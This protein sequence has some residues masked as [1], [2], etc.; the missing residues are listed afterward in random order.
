ME[1]LN[2]FKPKYK[3]DDIIYYSAILY[4]EKGDELP[5]QTYVGIIESVSGNWMFGYYYVVNK[6]EGT[7]YRP[8]LYEK[9][10]INTKQ[11]NQKHPEG[12]LV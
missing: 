7:I 10:I 6:P 9:R 12:W 1:L 5:E 2:I 11:F 3:V 8:F 4:N